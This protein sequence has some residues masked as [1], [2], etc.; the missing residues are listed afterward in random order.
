MTQEQVIND[1]PVSSVVWITD[2][3]NLIS[4]NHMA[5]SKESQLSKN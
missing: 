1:E 5:V 3:S 4:V 2:N